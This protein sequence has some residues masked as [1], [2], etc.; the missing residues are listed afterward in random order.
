VGRGCLAILQTST[1][2]WRLA[3]AFAELALTI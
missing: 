1:G 2:L 3:V